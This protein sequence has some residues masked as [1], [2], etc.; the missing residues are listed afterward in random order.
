MSWEERSD[1]DVVTRAGA[2]VEIDE[3]LRRYMLKVYN[4]M[5]LGLSVTAFVS[6]LFSVTSDRKSVV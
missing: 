3:G 4:Y 6:Y 2:G 5:T 1:A